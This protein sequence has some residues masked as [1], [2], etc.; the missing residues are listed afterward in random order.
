LTGGSPMRV[1]NDT[2]FVL[3][4]AVEGIPVSFLSRVIFCAAVFGGSGCLAVR[5]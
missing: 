4:P 2:R 3:S 1:G 5:D